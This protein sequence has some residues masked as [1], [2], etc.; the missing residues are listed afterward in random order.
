MGSKQKYSG[1]NEMYY[2]G[3]SPSVKDGL[4][5]IVP[6]EDVRASIYDAVK[7]SDFSDMD[8]DEEK[9]LSFLLKGDSYDTDEYY[10]ILVEKVNKNRIILNKV[11]P[12]DL[13]TFL[14]TLN[15]GQTL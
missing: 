7:A 8:V 5:L 2:I 14:D 4:V 15:S 11:K 13:D 12:L 1:E 3:V 6:D 10:G 9:I